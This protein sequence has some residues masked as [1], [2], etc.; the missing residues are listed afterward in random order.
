MDVVVTGIGVGMNV[1]VEVNP[2]FHHLS[3]P[4]LIP[5][6]IIEK[7]LCVGILCGGVAVG[8]KIE[9]EYNSPFYGVTGTVIILAATLVGITGLYFANMGYWNYFP[10]LS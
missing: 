2:I 5:A 3:L 6:L 4:I 8:N 1:Y 7:L 9:I 10:A